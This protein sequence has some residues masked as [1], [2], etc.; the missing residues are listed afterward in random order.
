M[1]FDEHT[2]LIKNENQFWKE[3]DDLSQKTDDNLSFQ[4]FRLW[5]PLSFFY[6]AL[7]SL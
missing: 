6:F 7:D 2:G 5:L 3:T 4:I 1:F